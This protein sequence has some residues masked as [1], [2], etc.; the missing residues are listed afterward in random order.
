MK[1]NPNWY[2]VTM[3]DDPRFSLFAG[4]ARLRESFG[5]L[6]FDGTQDYYALDG[7]HR[8]KAIKALLDPTSELAGRT[9]PEFKNEEVSVLVVVPRSTENMNEFMVRY[10]R[11]F[12]NLN[13]YAK[14]MDNVTNIIMDEDDVFAIITRS[15]ITQHNFFKWTG[16]QRESARIK[17]EGGKNINKT[18]SYFTSLETLYNMNIRLVSSNSRMSNGWNSE[19][20]S[21]DE[22]K[23][24]RPPEEVIEKLFL[25]L[26]KYWNGLISALPVLNNTP[27]TMR[28]HNAT[29]ESNTEDCI[30]FWPIGQEFLSDLARKLLDRQPDPEN[31]TVNS[32]NKALIPL[33]YV[34]SDFKDVPWRHLVLIPD[35]D[36]LRVWKIRNEDRK[37]AMTIAARII[38]WQIGLDQL[39]EEEIE[40]LKT[41]WKAMLLP[42]LTDNQIE[43]LWEKIEEDVH[44]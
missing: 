5:V 42:A 15:L 44:R 13:R 27:V 37:P 17:T 25:E 22:F 43:G 2:P 7:Q 21:L 41:E 29:D 18:D 4:D 16:R 35:G 23:R 39:A 9:P 12:G 3:E 24:F 14:P 33:Q 28:D 19:S 32:I 20:S 40:E 26:E 31:P 10:R 36:E 6:S 1:G 30:Y 8:L 38:Q 34:N 11:L